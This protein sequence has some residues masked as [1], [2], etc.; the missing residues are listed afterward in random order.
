MIGHINVF[1]EPAYFYVA[2][3][4]VFAVNVFNWLATCGGTVFVDGRGVRSSPRTARSFECDVIPSRRRL[5]NS[6][7]KAD[8]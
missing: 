3:N 5:W 6:G 4:R 7:V 8:S 2:D 1:G